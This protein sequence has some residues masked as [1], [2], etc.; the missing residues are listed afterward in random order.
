[1]VLEL[2]ARKVSASDEM[3]RG[4]MGPVSPICSQEAEFQ[5]LELEDTVRDSG[6]WEEVVH[7]GCRPQDVSEIRNNRAVPLPP[8]PFQP[9][10]RDPLSR[11]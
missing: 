7:G 9:T 3:S 8:D 11:N 6:R 1:M 10:L 2:W 5:A 4:G